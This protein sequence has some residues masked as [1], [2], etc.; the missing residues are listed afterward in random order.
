MSIGKKLNIAFIVI[1]VL[2]LISTVTAMLTSANVESKVDEALNYRVTQ[3]R[4]IDEIRFGIGMQGQY[5]QELLIDNSPE[6]KEQLEYYIQY[7]DEQIAQMAS[8]AN[9]KTMKAYVEEIY[10]YKNEFNEASDI[11]LEY[12]KTG[13]ISSGSRILKDRITPANDGILEVA[14]KMLD[15]QDNELKKISQETDRA[16]TLSNIVA[17]VMLIFVLLN[18]VLLMWFTRKQISNPLIK[19]VDAAE[20]IAT[21]DLSGEDLKYSSNDEIGKLA[22]AT[23]QMK[24]NLQTLLKRIHENS[25]HLSAAAEELSASTEEV[26]ASTNEMAHRAN[27]TLE[28]SSSAAQSA[29]ESSR[30]MEET[31]TGVQRI[32]ESTQHLYDNSNQTYQTALAGGKIIQQA[33]EQMNTINHSSEMMNNLV[34]KLSKQT[35][36]IENITNVITNITEQTNL[37]ALNAAIEAARAGEHGKGFAVVA[38]EVRKLAEESRQS[39]NQIV[40]L[41]KDIKLDTG[42]V[43]KAA[44][45]S[46]ESVTVGVKIIGDAGHAFQ[47]IVTAV[48]Q[49]NV[50]IEEISA[51]SEE[52]SASAEQ[53][54]ASAME[55][56]NGATNAS[57]NVEGI[58]AVIEEQTATMEQVSGVAVELSQ[59][60]QDLQEEINKFKLA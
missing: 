5:S 23:N 28:A 48:E 36:E 10:V 17:I 26:T 51:T 24:N 1:I 41:I 34:Q 42:N 52:I 50:Q 7:V 30:A 43:E 59:N 12:A 19:M 57:S 22:T 45:E 46:V 6:T 32:A 39:A 9:S 58:A 27:D 40:D 4:V 37:L 25:E 33:S 60:A 55:I 35:L 54:S 31:A 8:L 3:L 53:V 15:F 11:Y 47:E 56:A 44:E 14:Q 49:M 2:L 21:G 20:I 13:V 38:D 18:G 29:N 16:M